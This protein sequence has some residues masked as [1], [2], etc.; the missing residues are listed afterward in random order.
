[1]P[2]NTNT[3]TLNVNKICRLVDY[4][5]RA[6]WKSGKISLFV[7]A[8][9]LSITHTLTHTHL[10]VTPSETIFQLEHRKTE[11]NM[12]DG[13]V[14]RAMHTRQRRRQQLNTKRCDTNERK[15]EKKKITI[16]KRYSGHA[17]CDIINDMTHC[18]CAQAARSVCIGARC[19]TQKCTQSRLSDVSVIRETDYLFR[20]KSLLDSHEG[21]TVADAAAGKNKRLHIE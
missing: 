1:M 18:L 11:F 20:L 19:A 7:L 10:G 13:S 9:H 6:R 5:E 15:R 2:N 16:P 8:L 4:A 21:R 14:G 3:I 17:E 12:S